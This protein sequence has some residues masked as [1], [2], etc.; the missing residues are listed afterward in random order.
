M[1]GILQ[2]APRAL[3][4]FAPCAIVERK[5]SSRNSACDG[6]LQGKAVSRDGIG[7]EGLVGGIANH[8]W[9][10][11]ESALIGRC[12]AARDHGQGSDR[13]SDVSNSIHSW[14]ALSS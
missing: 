2:F 12:S 4:F 7:H 8:I 10:I 11:L 9:H 14:T 3:R 1:V 13:R 6:V 5:I